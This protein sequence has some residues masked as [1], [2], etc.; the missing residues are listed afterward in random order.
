MSARLISLRAHIGGNVTGDRGTFPGPGHSRRD[1]SLSLYDTG[2]RI[3]F[4]SFAGDDAGAV[5]AYLAGAGLDVGASR[6]ASP[7]ERR[8]MAKARR[9]AR[10]E[11]ER[12]DAEHRRIAMALYPAD[13]ELSG[14]ALD[15][16]A[17]RG[18][19][20]PDPHAELRFVANCPR[21]PYNPADQRSG[22]AIVAR[23]VDPYGEPL[24]VHVTFLRPKF[25][26]MLGP[27]SGG[28]V[29]L[30]QPTKTLAVAEG[31]ETAL[32]YTQLTGVPCWAARSAL[33]LEQF[34]PPT[35]V[36]RLIIAADGDAAGMRGA[37]ALYDSCR[38]YVHASIDAAPGGL[39]WN[40]VL[41]VQHGR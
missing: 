10:L 40:D 23:V 28:V 39:D 31:I 19:S 2:E 11:Y 4:N 27:Q 22:A 16:L 29:R 25:R 14:E 30:S 17:G 32:A 18:L 41:G 9:A 24:G 7:E 20:A 26:M 15:Y 1:R 12:R 5:Q 34:K 33:G 36:E 38:R 21:S 13:G 35:G 8:E 6:A 37:E 3:V